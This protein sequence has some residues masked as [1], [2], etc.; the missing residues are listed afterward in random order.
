M[1]NSQQKVCPYHSG[2]IERLSGLEKAVDHMDR[3]NERDHRALA[4]K[5]RL[6]DEEIKKL[7]NRLPNWAV[8]VISV[9]TGVVGWLL[10]IAT[11]VF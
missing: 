3:S 10:N 7:A 11:K 2:T 5:D 4:D 9:L 8:V 6:Q 1:T